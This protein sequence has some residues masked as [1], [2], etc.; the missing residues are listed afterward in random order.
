MITLFKKYFILHNIKKNRD[1]LN[2]IT[3]LS[4]KL[5]ED[6]DFFLKMLS[7]HK[8]CHKN[9][10]FKA[11]LS[12]MAPACQDDKDF[13]LALMQLS[14]VH[15][16]QYASDRIKADKHVMEFVVSKNAVMVKHAS[17]G[18]RQDLNFAY[19]TMAH[20]QHGSVLQAFD[21]SIKNNKEF[22]LQILKSKVNYTVYPSL[23][24]KLK[25]DIDVL[26]CIKKGI[27]E[28][29]EIFKLLD[30][31]LKND[32]SFV[33]EMLKMNPYVMPYVGKKIKQIIK[34]AD[35]I[36]ALENFSLRE[37]LLTESEN[38]IKVGKKIKI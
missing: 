38:T 32:V 6:K 19:Y 14:S 11:L 28:N 29:G 1:Y 35:P 27:K 18:L 25:R 12:L 8:N 23:S 30:S 22:A 36:E 20:A 17:Y 34:N 9:R 16:I 2:S 37:K 3:Y 4:P 5:S 24:A 10:Q 13:V 15:N 33:L 7:T 26:N 31:K 21:Y